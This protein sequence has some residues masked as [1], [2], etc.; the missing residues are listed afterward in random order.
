M[1]S[2]LQIISDYVIGHALRA[3][4]TGAAQDLQEIISAE[5]VPALPALAILDRERVFREHFELG[6]EA[7]STRWNAGS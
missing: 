4:T 1:W 3:A 7:I 5:E 2:L 6:L